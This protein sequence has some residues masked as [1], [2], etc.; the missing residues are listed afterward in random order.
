MDMDYKLIYARRKSVSM[1]IEDDGTLT[2]RAPLGM[3]KKEIEKIL[4]KYEYKLNKSREYTKAKADRIKECDESLLRKKAE[5]ILPLLIEKHSAE[6][7]VSPKKIKLTKA[8]KRF[9]SCTSRGNLCFSLY[10]F[11][12]P[13]EAIE[14]VIVHEL[15]HLTEFN[16]SKA[17]Y[18]LIERQLPDWKARREILKKW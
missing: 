5:E 12:F 13:T 16:H 11:T 9:G 15:A 17:F 3:S 8:K 6:M 14:Y 2:V 10:L 18:A 4:L 7:G 1:K